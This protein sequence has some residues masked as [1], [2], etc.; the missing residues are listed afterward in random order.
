MKLSEI[1]EYIVDNYPESNIAYNNDVI[2]GYKKEWYEE[3]LIDPL[4]DFYMHE[5]LGLCG[6]GNPEFT[7]ETIRRY[8]NIR[9]EFV[10][11]KIDYQEV[12]DRYKN[13]LL[14]DYNNDIQYGL[15]QFMMYILDDKDFTT[16]GSSIGGCWLTKKGQR[17]LTVLEAWRAREDKE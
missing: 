11:S 13:D 10:I 14:L 9:N 16:H 12:I 15:L 8:L 5:E 3:S 7:Y 17:L 2:K 4:L 1:A 6:C